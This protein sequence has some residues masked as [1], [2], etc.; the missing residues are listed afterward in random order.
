MQ[1]PSY[2]IVTICPQ[3]LSPHLSAFLERPVASAANITVR[4][5]IATDLTKPYRDCSLSF[6][7]TV[8]AWAAPGTISKDELGPWLNG[9]GSMSI[10]DSD[11]LVSLDLF[12]QE[13][14]ET[15][16]ALGG[17]YP[18][19][20]LPKE[21]SQLAYGSVSLLMHPEIKD[22]LITRAYRNIVQPNV[23]ADPV[24]VIISTLSE[25]D[26]LADAKLREAISLLMPS[27]NPSSP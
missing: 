26:E 27:E 10:P 15:T 24:G 11:H 20:N 25:S 6:A 14:G 18:V 2:R 5:A 22:D 13:V 4:D 3:G 12:V 7:G 21:R 19:A 9:L 1:S 17:F 23:A 8:F 16:V